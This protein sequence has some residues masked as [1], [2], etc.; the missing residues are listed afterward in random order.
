[1]RKT[2]QDRPTDAVRPAAQDEGMSSVP[3]YIYPFV[4]AVVAALA[5]LLLGGRVRD[6]AGSFP[7]L[8]LYAIAVACVVIGFAALW[9]GHQG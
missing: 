6:D 4:F 1:M 9:L 7:R 8:I 2:H 3:T 5:G